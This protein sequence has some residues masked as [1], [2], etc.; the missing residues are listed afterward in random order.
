VPAVQRYE[1]RQADARSAYHQW[2]A[3]AREKQERRER[4]LN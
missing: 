4:E 1:Q 3:A 2:C